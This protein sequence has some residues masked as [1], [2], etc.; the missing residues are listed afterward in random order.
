MAGILQG[1]IQKRIKKNCL[2]LKTKIPDYLKSLEK[3][4]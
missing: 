4:K 3:K 2:I 1:N